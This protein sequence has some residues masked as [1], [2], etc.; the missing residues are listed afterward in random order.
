MSPRSDPVKSAYLFFSVKHLNHVYCKA[1]NSFFMFGEFR[2]YKQCFVNN[3]LTFYFAGYS[4]QCIVIDREAFLCSS[5]SI[6]MPSN[7]LQLRNSRAFRP[8]V[9]SCITVSL[10]RTVSRASAMCSA[11]FETNLMPYRQGT[12]KVQLCNETSIP[13]LSLSVLEPPQSV[14]LG[15]VLVSEQYLEAWLLATQGNCYW[16]KVATDDNNHVKYEVE[17]VPGCRKDFFQGANS[18]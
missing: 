18:Y 3:L 17:N 2:C 14:S 10:N 8:A 11:L 16:S 9:S 13:Q 12:C 7:F 5:Q 15:P 1:Y 6:W 4:V